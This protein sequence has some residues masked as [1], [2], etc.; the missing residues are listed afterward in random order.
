MAGNFINPQ[1]IIKNLPLQE[2]M[3]VADFGCGSGFF[4]LAMA[5]KIKPNGQ[6]VAIDIWKPALDVLT[7]KAKLTGL[8]NIIETK[9]GDLEAP[10]TLNLKENYFD[11]VLVSNVLFQ[12]EDKTAVLKEAYRILKPNGYLVIIEWQPEK[13]P[14]APLLKAIDK[15]PLIKLVAEIGFEIDREI[16][17]LPTH[18]SLLAKKHI[19]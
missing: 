17:S 15:E 6:V 8:F 19:K 1:E 9:Q 11:L 3:V 13:L 5:E 10:K 16:A 18:Y 12:I 14:N 4:S 7:L 2:G